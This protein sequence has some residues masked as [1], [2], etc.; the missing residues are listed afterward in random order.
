M[1]HLLFALVH[2][3]TINLA[4]QSRNFDWLLQHFPNLQSTEH[5][6]PCILYF[7]QFPP[8]FNSHSYFHIHIP[9]HLLPTSLQNFLLYFSKLQPL[10]FQ[11]TSTLS[12]IMFVRDRLISLYFSN[13]GDFNLLKNNFYTL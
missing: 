6:F 10:S 1:F 9:G 4:D 5:H 11:T 12:V 7:S 2:G 8:P 3:N 13:F